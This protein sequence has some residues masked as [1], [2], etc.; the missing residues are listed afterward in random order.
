MPRSIVFEFR[1]LEADARVIRSR[2]GETRPVRAHAPMNARL[3]VCAQRKE[4]KKKKEIEKEERTEGG[5][6][7]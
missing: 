5:I 1:Y 3:P 4:K 6:F 7:L 2:Q